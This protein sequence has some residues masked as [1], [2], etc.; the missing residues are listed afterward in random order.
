MNVRYWSLA[1]AGVDGGTFK[2]VS[3]G[4]ISGRQRIIS[5]ATRSSS[6]D[7][8]LPVLGIIFLRHAANR[9]D[10]ATK[11]IAADEAEG[12]A[13]QAV[14]DQ[15]YIRRRSAPASRRARYDWIMGLE[16]QGSVAHARDQCDEGRRGEVRAA[17]PIRRRSTGSSSRKFSKTHPGR[18]GSQT[19][20]I[21]ADQNP[22]D[23]SLLGGTTKVY[24][25]PNKNAA[26]IANSAD[27]GAIYLHRRADESEAVVQPAGHA[28]ALQYRPGQRPGGLEAKG[29]T[30]GRRVSG[31]NLYVRIP[32]AIGTV[33]NS[34]P[35]EV[36]NS[37]A[38]LYCIGS[39]IVEIDNLVLSR[40]G[41]FNMYLDRGVLIARHCGFEWSESNGT[42]DAA[43]N[44]VL[45]RIAGGM[46]QTT[47]WRPGPSRRASW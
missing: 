46:R 2:D 35:M 41:I 22:N 14:I 16:R 17:P 9:F 30:G 40:G 25:R 5:A 10:A 37:V 6:S 21:S 45:S 13:Q 23:W 8:F 28:A 32:D 38:T 29:A 34:T 27:A 26:G 43:G 3:S 1:G 31:G 18:G 36:N 33:P 4:L 11:Q 47:I 44:S 15:D 24:F 39:P 42:E 12:H 19:K 7:Y 20:I